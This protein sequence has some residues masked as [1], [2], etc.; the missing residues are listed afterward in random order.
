MRRKIKSRNHMVMTDEDITSDFE[1]FRDVFLP[2]D[3]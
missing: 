2:Y 3:S 1:K